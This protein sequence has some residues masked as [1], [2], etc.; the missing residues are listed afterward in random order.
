M[1][2]LD[3][4]A[5][6]AGYDLPWALEE[7]TRNGQRCAN[8]VS[9]DGTIVCEIRGILDACGNRENGELIV[10]AV[11]SLGALSALPSSPV[12]EMVER[13]RDRAESYRIGGPSSEHTAALLDEAASTL[14]TLSVRNAELER[15]V[16]R[17]HARLEIDH[18]WVMGG[19][20]DSDL[21]CLE[22]PFAERANQIDGIECRDATIHELEREVKRLREAQQWQSIETAPK[23]GTEIIYVNKFGEIGFCYWSKAGGAFDQSMWWD[24]LADDECCPV[25]WLPR[26]TLPAAP[27]GGEHE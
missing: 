5:L 25:A 22:I 1:T 10:R 20:D 17:C 9:N 27:Q 24:D 13:L 4:K 19:N 15:E 11:N 16:E 23:D 6:E 3:E 26:D 12:S 7:F 21:E 14:T 18:E 2:H 8:I